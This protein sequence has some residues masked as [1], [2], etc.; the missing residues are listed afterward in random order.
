[1]DIFH[2]AFRLNEP[3]LRRNIDLLFLRHNRLCCKQLPIVRI[4]SDASQLVFIGLI[5]QLHL[6]LDL[7]QIRNEIGFLDNVVIC[8]IRYLPHIDQVFFYIIFRLFHQLRCAV[9]ALLSGSGREQDI[10]DTSH[11]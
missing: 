10:H 3:L 2:L 9:Y 4:Y 6:F 7:C 5:K 1:M 11:A 8:C